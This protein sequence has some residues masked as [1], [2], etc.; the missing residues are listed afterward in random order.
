MKNNKTGLKVNVRG[1]VQGVGFRPFIYSQAIKHNLVGW[2]RNT[3][4]G[5]E[6]E[7]NGPHEKIRSFLYTLNHHLPPLA[8][9]DEIITQQIPVDNYSNFTIL[10]SHTEEGQFIPISPDVSTCPDC[11]RELFDSHNRRFRYPFINCTN[12]GPRFTIIKDIPYDRPNT[13]MATFS[14]CQ[15]CQKEYENPLDRR[16]H[17]QPTACPVCGPQIWFECNDKIIARGE[18]SLLA[19]R[20][21]LKQGKIIAIKGLGGFHLACDATNANCVE[22]LR[23]RKKRSEKPF[24]LMAFDI[25]SIEQHCQVSPHDYDLLSSHQRPIVLLER[26]NGSSIVPQIAPNQAMLG[27]MLPYTPLHLLLLEP[28]DSFPEVL[29]MTSGNLSE[30]P[31]S[32]RDDEVIEHLAGLADAF[33]MHNRSI[34]MRIDDSVVRSWHN[35][36]LIIRR[37]RGIAP[38]SIQLP[39]IIPSILATGTELKNTFCL[40]RQNYAFISHHIGDMENY[41]TLCSFEESIQHYEK[42][43]RI[44]PEIIACDLHPNYLASRYAIKRSEDEKIP[45]LEIQHHHAHIASCLAENGWISNDPIIGLAFDGTGYGTDGNIWGGEFLLSNYSGF[46]RLFH[47]D[48]IPMPGGDR[49]IRNPAYMALS[50]LWHAN[51]EWDTILPPVQYICAPERNMLKNQLNQHI[52]TP[53]TSSLGR[54]FDAASALIGI[55]QVATYEGQPA[56]ELENAAAIDETKFYNLSINNDI[57][58]PTSLWHQII[59]DWYSGLSK[60]KL[61]ARFHNSIIEV[62]RTICHEIRIKNNC[63]TVVLSGGVWQNHYL[64]QRSYQKLTDDGFFVLTHQRV[65]TNDGGVSLGQALVAAYSYTH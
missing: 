8:R 58:D 54:M 4:S 35:K 16:F 15:D 31:I 42:L 41:E 64:L 6:I 30:E 57:I 56:I 18:D 29:V 61:A 7:I 17:A 44:H 46:E 28:D 33:L 52:N 60:S 47:F 20:K 65:P 22:E 43:F 40:T 27:F 2:V 9:I 51:I 26:K 14:M 39:K 53:L 1:I 5:V 21:M 19:A 48:N 34:H 59:V 49:A 13:T 62:I 3:S 32:Y 11:Q 24:A 12:C 36:S 25:S 37:A 55:C 45:R 23:L 50:H 63:N 10:A 38:D